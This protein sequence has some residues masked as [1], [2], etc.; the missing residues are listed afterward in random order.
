MALLSLSVLVVT[1]FLI[2][3]ALRMFGCVEWWVGCSG[4]R[5]FVGACVA[6]CLGVA[7]GGCVA[8]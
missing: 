6:R 1:F 3:I 7:I 8:F 2:K 4:G 5:I